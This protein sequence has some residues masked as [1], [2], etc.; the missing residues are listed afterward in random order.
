[1]RLKLKIFNLINLIKIKEFNNSVL[2][3]QVKKI[4]ENLQFLK[5]L[6][7]EFDSYK[8]VVSDFKTASKN[9]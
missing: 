6:R 5:I 2:N 3:E 7:N 9:K 8:Y 4:K 1:M